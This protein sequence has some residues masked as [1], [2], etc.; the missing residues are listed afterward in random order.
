MG[1]VSEDV[2]LLFLAD[3][4]RNVLICKQRSVGA[5]GDTAGRG[6][7]R[8]EKEEDWGLSHVHYPD[9]STLELTRSNI[10]V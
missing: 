7:G 3:E 2:S 10:W 5:D 6:G 4:D 9:T 8:R 1:T